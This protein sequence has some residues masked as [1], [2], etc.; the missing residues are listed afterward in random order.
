MEETEEFYSVGK[1]VTE[2]IPYF[3]KGK[4]VGERF[5]KN[6]HVLLVHIHSLCQ[7]KQGACI[8]TT[9]YFSKI[10]GK[11]L[12]QIT[13]YI[14]YLKDTGQ[15]FVHT[16]NP[17]KNENFRR[18]SKLFYKKRII[19]SKHDHHPDCYEEVNNIYFSESTKKE[20]I[21][22]INDLVIKSE[23]NVR[24]HKKLIDYKGRPLSP[25]KTGTMTTEYF[26]ARLEREVPKVEASVCVAVEAP[27]Q[28][29]VSICNSIVEPKN[30][31]S[32]SNELDNDPGYLQFMK[33]RRPPQKPEDEEKYEEPEEGHE[34]RD[35]M[36]RLYEKRVKESDS[37][38][39][40]LENGFKQEEEEEKPLDFKIKLK[41]INPFNKKPL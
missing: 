25:K 15:I 6:A 5:K 31:K 18:S 17:I 19:Q 24:T 9:K 32:V 14:K 33:N 4:P 34:L 29:P 21:S 8:A 16:S 12:R 2:E 37:F 1:E 35:L 27:K 26:E 10:M 20:K 11:G 3:V 39:N 22:K 28:I 38:W 13:Y 41:L 30:I 36:E 40:E 23:I 7:R